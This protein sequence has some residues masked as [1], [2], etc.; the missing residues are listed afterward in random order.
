M[1]E[2]KLALNQLAINHQ[3]HPLVFTVIKQ[4]DLPVLKEIYASTRLEELA[5]TQWTE[6]QKSDFIEQQFVAQHKHYQTQFNAAELLL[7]RCADQAI[8]RL[9]L[10][11]NKQSLCLI[12]ITLLNP[13]RH[14]HL[15]S[16]ILTWLIGHAI[17]QNKVI[18]LHVEKH[19][20]AHNWYL[21][22]GFLDVENR[23]IYQYMEWHP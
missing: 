14:K 7:I 10:N 13:F 20:P 8:G 21:N 9:Y 15:G 19:N 11:E 12:D 5:L 17:N 16:Q 2:L 3:G 4:T 23:G 22:N 6:Q 18:T 1:P